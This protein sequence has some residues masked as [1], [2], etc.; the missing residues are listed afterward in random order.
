MRTF[1]F[2]DSNCQCFCRHSYHL[3]IQWKHQFTK[4]ILTS[5]LVLVYEI[6]ILEFIWILDM[7]KRF[8][9]Y[10]VGG[11]IDW[12]MHGWQ[13]ICDQHGFCSCLFSVLTSLKFI[14]M[15]NFFFL[16]LS[17]I[18]V[19]MLFQDLQVIDLKRLHQEF[20]FSYHNIHWMHSCRPFPCIRSVTHSWNFVVISVLFYFSPSTRCSPGILFFVWRHTFLCPLLSYRQSNLQGR[21][22]S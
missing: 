16:G 8:N 11:L 20:V 6:L 4:M 22:P 14:I 10:V 13:R 15:L 2:L 5:F 3:H 7:Q 19:C 18:L 17:S 21:C 12:L 1:V 9:Q